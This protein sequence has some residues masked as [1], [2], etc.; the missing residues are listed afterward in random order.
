M[1]KLLIPFIVGAIVLS[2]CSLFESASKDFVNEAF[3]N[4]EEIDYYDYD[5]SFDGDMTVGGESINFAIEY[6]GQ[7]DN[8]D[9][10]K[11][12][13]TMEVDVEMSTEEFESQSMSGEMASDGDSLYFIINEISDFNGDLSSE[14][15]E[16]FKGQW[17]SLSLQDEI[18]EDISPFTTFSMGDEENMTE[19]QKELKKLYEKTEFFTDVELLKTEYGYYVYTGKL[20]KKAAYKF[21]QKAIKMQGQSST[22][23]EEDGLENMME[24]IEVD[25]MMYVDEVENVLTKVTGTMIMT[26]LEGADG[27]FDFSMEFMNLH[28][29]VVIEI[30]EDVE[31]FDPM[32]IFAAMM[33]VDPA[34]MADPG[35]MEETIMIDDSMYE[36]LGMS[37]A[38]LEGIEIDITE[39]GY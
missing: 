37:P 5:F 16:P 8:T 25:V 27:N 38:D 7:Q 6:A 32:M 13:F 20:D 18:L 19:E 10:A 21:I 1:K 11:P 12:K 35:L 30:P 14:M 22:S 36:E 34:M 15:V 31:E 24:S 23:T 9:K 2:G 4:L 39:F 29:P 3:K 17:Y 28:T 33:G 26:D